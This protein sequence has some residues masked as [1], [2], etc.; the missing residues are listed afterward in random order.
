M[1]KTLLIA[2][3]LLN[4]TSVFAAKV[5]FKCYSMDEA[6]DL[7]DSKSLNRETSFTTY[8]ID[9]NKATVTYSKGKVEV[10]NAK[11]AE[12]NINDYKGLSKLDFKT[13]KNTASAYIIEEYNKKNP[14]IIVDKKVVQERYDYKKNVFV[15]YDIYF[16]QVTMKNA[17]NQQAPIVVNQGCTK[18]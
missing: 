13:S 17:Y 9:G 4:T 5:D 2:L 12:I 1:K 16:G 8:S 7:R 14:T 3:V 15:N 11:K 6:V 10:Y 18:L